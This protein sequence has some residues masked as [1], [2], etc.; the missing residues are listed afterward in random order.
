MTLFTRLQELNLPSSPSTKAYDEQGSLQGWLYT[1]IKKKTY[2]YKR[3]YSILTKVFHSAHNADTL[4]C[5]FL[6]SVLTGLHCMSFFK[7]FFETESYKIDFIISEESPGG[8]QKAGKK[9]KVQEMTEGIL[10]VTV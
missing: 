2:I 6:V 10:K 7:E 4:P 3:S 5:H 8:K 9:R 1:I